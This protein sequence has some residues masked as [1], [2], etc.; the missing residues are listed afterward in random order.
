MRSE[1]CSSNKFL[2]DADATDPGTTVWEPANKVKPHPFLSF[3]SYLLGQ[4]ESS[5]LD[6][7]LPHLSPLLEKIIDTV[8]MIYQQTGIMLGMTERRKVPVPT[9][10]NLIVSYNS[11]WEALWWGKYRQWW[12]LKAHEIKSISHVDVA[13]K[14]AQSCPTLWDPMDYTVHGIFQVR[15]LE[16]VAFPFS[17]GSSQPRDQT[18]ISR[19]AGGFFTSWATR[20]AHLLGISVFSQITFC[21]NGILFGRWS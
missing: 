13:V 7:K 17:R 6:F 2:D 8:N 5:L 10:N 12:K 15:I 14:V 19:I 18:Q 11:V 3:C 21:S 1:I 4:I 9:S 16:W 20:E